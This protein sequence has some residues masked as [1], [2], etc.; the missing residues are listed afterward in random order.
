MKLSPVLAVLAALSLSD[1]GRSLAQ[2]PDHLK[3]YKVKDP[4]ARKTYTAD[5]GGLVPEPGCVIK[6]PAKLACVPAT[7]TN[8]QPVP[9]GGGG[10]GSPG[11]VLCY[12]I[13]CRPGPFPALVANDQF[14]SRTV[15]VVAAKMLCAPLEQPGVTTTTATTTP[16]TSTS[17]TTPCG[18]AG[19]P[20][21]GGSACTTGCCAS[22]ACVAEGEACGAPVCSDTSGCAFDD[23][24]DETGTKTQS[25]T[26]AMCTAGACLDGAPVPTVVGCGTRTT[27]GDI[28]GTQSCGGG[29]IR[30]LC[31]SAVDNTCTV[32]C[33][34]CYC[35]TCSVIGQ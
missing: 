2:V 13:R 18:G 23:I 9:P 24:C 28:C 14:G 22:G 3:C 35:A 11:A 10:T 20:C 25:C 21:C 16:S 32:L 15:S 31:C 7:K 29:N 12:K 17:T 30:D 8:V 34:T 4:Q 19:Q 33:S 26:Q 1:P 27:D 5:L 6:V